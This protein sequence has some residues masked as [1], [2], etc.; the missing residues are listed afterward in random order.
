M[1]MG[2]SSRAGRYVTQSHGYRAFIPTPLPP[3][4]PLHYDDELLDLLSQADRALAGWRTH[5]RL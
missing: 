2:A 5:L 4:P 1:E 3:D